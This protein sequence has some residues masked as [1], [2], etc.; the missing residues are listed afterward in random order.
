MALFDKEEAKTKQ[1]KKCLLK[2]FNQ[3]RTLFGKKKGEI[4]PD[5]QIQC[6]CL[7]SHCRTTFTDEKV[8]HYYLKGMLVC[9]FSLLLSEHLQHAGVF[10]TCATSISVLVLLEKFHPSQSA[11]QREES[12]DFHLGVS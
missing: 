5:E 4:N 2:S 10:K 8:F 7:Q 12:V 1:E 11:K 6:F 3:L 9:M